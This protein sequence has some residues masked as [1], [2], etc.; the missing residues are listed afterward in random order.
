MRLLFAGSPALSVP[1]LEAAA[2]EQEVC[3]VLTAPDRP[4]GRSGRP[5]PT[6][7]KRRAL[8]LGLEVIQPERIDAATAERV[9]RLQPEALVA[10][11]YGEIFRRDFLETFPRGGVNL[12]PSLLPRH[13]GPSPIPAAILAGDAETGVTIQRLALRMDAGDI[14]AQEAIPLEGTETT[15]SLSGRLAVLGAGLLV[16]T[17]RELAQHEVEPRPQEEER[18][19]YCRLVRKEDGRIDWSLEAAQIERMIR[20]YN[21]WPGA[22]TTFRGRQLTLQAGGVYPH[23]A[24]AQGQEGLVAGSDKRYGILVTAGRG[25]LSVSRLQLEARRSLDWQSFLNGHRDLVGSRLG[26]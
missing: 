17:L 23:P 4:A 16:R 7:V 10:V 21:P 12:H 6:A 14:L 5:V 13:R 18:A 9:R 8:E 15:A 24:A 26:D 11:A 22:F 2:A 3:A 19:T 20:A 25:V 1:S